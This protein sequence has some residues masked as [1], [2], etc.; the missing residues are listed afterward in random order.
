[1]EGMQFDSPKGPV[2]FRAEDHQLLQS[3][4]GFK[5]KVDPS[6]PWAVPELTHEFTISEMTVPIANKR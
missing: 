4:Y 2:Q 3:M 6:Q 1:M 5:L